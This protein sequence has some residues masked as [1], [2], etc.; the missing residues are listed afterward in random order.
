MAPYFAKMNVHPCESKMPPAL[1]FDA[2]FLRLI[3]FFFSLL[4]IK[5]VLGFYSITQAKTTAEVKLNCLKK[6]S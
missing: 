6:N 3:L 1:N 2:Y 4:H 5:L